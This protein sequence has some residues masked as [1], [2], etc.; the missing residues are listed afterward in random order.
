MP[1]KYPTTN[2]RLKPKRD[3]I[4][5]V[6]VE[7]TFRVDC[8]YAAVGAADTKALLRSVSGKPFHDFSAV[9]DHILENCSELFDR[10]RQ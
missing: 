2:F 10:V 4:T 1:A 5:Q 8:L 6:T 9:I 7:L 3:I